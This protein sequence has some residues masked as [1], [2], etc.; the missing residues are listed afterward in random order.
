MEFPTTS[1]LARTIL[2]VGGN[3]C[4]SQLN[5]CDAS[6]LVAQYKDLI[7]SAKEIA[8]AVTVLS[9]CPRRRQLSRSRSV[10]AP[11]MQ[12]Y[13]F[14]VMRWACPLSITTVLF[15]CKTVQSMMDIYYLTVSI[16][17]NPQQTNSWQTSNCSWGMASQAP[18]LIT[19]GEVIL[20]RS[21]A[22]VAP[23]PIA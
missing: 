8:T 17:P 14:Y 4:D 2:V 18:M 12:G 9:V 20:N 19:A 6:E 3:D 16:S 15:I 1:K 21:Q 11:S 5:Q 13:V 7:L 10:L 23:A 22:L